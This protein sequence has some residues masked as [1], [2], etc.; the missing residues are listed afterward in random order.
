MPLDKNPFFLPVMQSI[1]MIAGENARIQAEERREERQI[2]F[3]ERKTEREE[4]VFQRNL[5]TQEMG[6]LTKFITEYEQNVTAGAEPDPDLLKSVVEKRN[7]MI[8]EG[9]YPQMMAEAP[10]VPKPEKPVKPGEDLVPLSERTAAFYGYGDKLVKR[11]TKRILES[12]YRNYFKPSD[13]KVEK[14][15]DPLTIIGSMRKR[16][17]AVF[18]KGVMGKGE[19][20]REGV[21]KDLLRSYQ[22]DLQEI[23]QDYRS[24]VLSKSEAR[25]KAVQLGTFDQFLAL[26][27]GDRDE[28]GER[29][30]KL[31]ELMEEI[32]ND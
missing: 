8:Q 10:K 2:G 5:Q 14:T 24:G 12:N 26:E 20:W 13:E 1:D 9:V 18:D 7:A 11:E 17:Q 31:I 16:S 28:I 6:D 15:E 30:D 4:E 32:A 22:N 21:G 27:G 29:Q 25:M 19:D 3:E 23:E